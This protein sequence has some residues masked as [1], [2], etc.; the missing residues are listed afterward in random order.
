MSKW[1]YSFKYIAWATHSFIAYLVVNNKVEVP[2]K[3]LKSQFIAPY[4][5]GKL[6]I[7][8]FKVIIDQIFQSVNCHFK[9]SMCCLVLPVIIKLGG[10]SR[11]VD[12]D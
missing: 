3:V 11:C 1:R 9:N 5:L 12:S 4:S 6:L 2:L 10:A 7:K 8:I